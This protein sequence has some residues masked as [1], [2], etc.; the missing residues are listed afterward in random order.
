MYHRC[1]NTALP[2]TSD[3]YKKYW[4][5]FHRVCIWAHIFSSRIIDVNWM[6]SKKRSVVKSVVW[7][8]IGVFVLGVITWK[9][10][11]NLQTTTSIT[12]LFHSVNLILYYIHE[13]FWE[14]MDWGL[15]K[16]TDLELDEQVKIM[17]R[18]RKLG[19]IE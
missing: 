9:L 7:R 17:D 4:T 14:K 8:T 1:I 2:W 13:R 3:M 12:L 16:K 10:T 6:E 15:L 19:Y 11:N 18:L 5:I